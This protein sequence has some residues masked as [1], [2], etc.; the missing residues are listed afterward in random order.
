[1]SPWGASVV[2]G[3]Q[4]VAEHP[5]SLC[6]SLT[7]YFPTLSTPVS[8]LHINGKSLLKYDMPHKTTANKKIYNQFNQKPSRVSPPH[9]NIYY[10]RSKYGGHCQTDIGS[11]PLPASAMDVIARRRAYYNSILVGSTFGLSSCT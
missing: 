7:H 9:H 1:M 2:D 5:E 6:G 8:L 11:V 10:P 4:D 3:L